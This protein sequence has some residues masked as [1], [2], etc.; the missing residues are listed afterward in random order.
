MANT[1]C[2]PPSRLEYQTNEDEKKADLPRFSKATMI[3]IFL[4]V[5]IF[6]DII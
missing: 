5:M 4:R 6:N 3:Y 2:F 1:L